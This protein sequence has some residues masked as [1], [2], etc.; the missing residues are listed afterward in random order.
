VLLGCEI[1][2]CPASTLPPVGNGAAKLYELNKT[3]KAAKLTID[4]VL[5]N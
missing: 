1:V 3:V 2:A 5:Q 4:F